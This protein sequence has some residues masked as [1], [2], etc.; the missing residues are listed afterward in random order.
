MSQLLRPL[1]DGEK[2]IE[3]D[4][5][6]TN[7]V[8]R[9]VTIPPYEEFAKLH[10]GRCGEI[11]DTCLSSDISC[12]ECFYNLVVEITKIPKVELTPPVKKEVS[13]KRL[14]TTVVYWLAVG[15]VTVGYFFFI[16]CVK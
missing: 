14:N 8:F 6:Y 1:E 3:R 9:P 5:Y 11:G 2:P 13:L 16:T 10:L 7:Q 4:I 12:E 15:L